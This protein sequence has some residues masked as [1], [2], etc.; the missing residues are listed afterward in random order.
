MWFV[1]LHHFTSESQEAHIIT[2]KQIVT[3]L[4]HH[5]FKNVFVVSCHL[6]VY[7]PKRFVMQILLSNKLL[8]V[9]KYCII[10]Q[11]KYR[12]DCT[13]SF[14]WCLKFGANTPIILDLANWTLCNYW[15]IIYWTLYKWSLNYG[16]I[17]IIIPKYPLLPNSR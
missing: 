6:F 17:W 9:V 2:E 15:I 12:Y 16:Q 8:L 10:P 14:I 13:T 1:E 4:F 11:Y 7:I 5:Q 3:Y